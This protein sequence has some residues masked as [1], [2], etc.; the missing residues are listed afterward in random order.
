ML[1]RFALYLKVFAIFS[2]ALALPALAQTG[3]PAQIIGQIYDGDKR[4]AD[5]IFI[6]PK[7]GSGG[8]GDIRQVTIANPRGEVSSFAMKSFKKEI[9]ESAKKKFLF[10]WNQL[11]PVYEQ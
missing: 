3:S 8:V 5:V 9:S 1:R 7:L 11:K 6:G 10:R 2:I 4:I